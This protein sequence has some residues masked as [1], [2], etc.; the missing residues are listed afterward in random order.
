MEVS[1]STKCFLRKYKEGGGGGGGGAGGMGLGSTLFP[2]KKR[3]P[4][5][6]VGLGLGLGLETT[7][8]WNSILQMK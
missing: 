7:Y 5:N 8:C 6:E 1:I 3:D 2:G 4:G